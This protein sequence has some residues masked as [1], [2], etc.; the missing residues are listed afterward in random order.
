[1]VEN[2]LLTIRTKVFKEVTYT[3]N[4]GLFTPPSDSDGFIPKMPSGLEPWPELPMLAE[5]EHE[6]MAFFEDSDD[7]T[8]DSELPEV[9]PIPPMSPPSSPPSL[10]AATPPV[11]KKRTRAPVNNS[12]LEEK[13]GKMSIINANKACKSRAKPTRK[14]K[15]GE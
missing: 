8:S 11:T 14:R 15:V 6:N 3:E 7:T 10:P 9:A 1:M 5:D 4:N 12:R 2:D 13:M